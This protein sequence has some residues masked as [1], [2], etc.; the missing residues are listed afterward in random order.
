MGEIPKKKYS[1]NPNM[2]NELNNNRLNDSAIL[3]DTSYFNPN[4]NG[5]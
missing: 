1:L 4:H 3:N 2:I 5:G